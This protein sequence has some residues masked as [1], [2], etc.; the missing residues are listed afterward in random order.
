MRQIVSYNFVNCEAFIPKIH[1]SIIP[2]FI[3][4]DVPLNSV[5]IDSL[6]CKIY[7]IDLNFGNKLSLYDPDDK[8][9]YKIPWECLNIQP[10]Y[11]YLFFN[12]I[13]VTI[14]PKI[15]GP[16]VATLHVMSSTVI[17]KNTEPFYVL[18]KYFNTIDIQLNVGVNDIRLPRYGI[19]R[20]I[21]IDG[22][23]ADSLTNFTISLHGCEHTNLD[24]DGFI[25]H[26]S[27]ISKD[28]YF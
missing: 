3:K 12:Q 28:C 7:E 25:A 23:S 20:G 2:L 15:E 21:F 11:N 9:I 1:D 16:V 17:E 27:P 13:S 6:N 24:H 22:V 10:I 8:Y 14:T 26:A 5:R 4:S 18:S 19:S